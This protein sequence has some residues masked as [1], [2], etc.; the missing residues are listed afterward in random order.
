MAH[1][2][3]DGR[4]AGRHGARHAFLVE[5]PEVFQ[6]TAA[7]GQDQ[8]IEALRISALQGP[9]DLCG[10]FAPLYGCLLYTSRCV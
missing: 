4:D 5:A 6:R 8:R 10:G 1:G 7:A 3:D 9:D 2:A